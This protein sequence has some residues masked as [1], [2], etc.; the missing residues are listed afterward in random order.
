MTRTLA[1]LRR[2]LPHLERLAP[3]LAM[4]A[5]LGAV[6]GPGLELYFRDPF[7]ANRIPDDTRIQLYY[8]YHFSDPALFAGDPIGKY[9][10]DGIGDVVRLLY[11]IAAKLGDPMV[12]SRALPMLLLL[13]TVAGL[14]V[15][16]NNL[17]GKAGAMVAMTF[18]LAAAVVHDRVVGGLPRAFAYPCFAWCAAALTG[19]RVYAFIGVIVAG[20]GCYP[21][22]AVVG[23]IALAVWLLVMPREDRGAARDWSFRRR[24]L[25]LALTAVAIAAM[26]APFAL[27][28]RAYGETIRPSMVKEYPEA[29]PGGRVGGLDRPPF[30]PFFRA[31]APVVRE[32]ALARPESMLVPAVAAPIRKSGTWSFALPLLLAV[33]VG[34]GYLRLGLANAAARRLAALAVATAAGYVLANALTPNLVV[35]QRYVQ[36]PVPILV[37]LAIAG[38]LYGLV[39]RRLREDAT[40]RAVRIAAGSVLAVAALF[41]V[42]IGPG[43]PLGKRPSYTLRKPEKGLY[44]ALKALPKSALIA[45]WPV[46]ALDNIALATRRTPFLS[47]ETHYP[48]HTGMTQLMRQRMRALVAAYFATDEAPLLRL[49]N[50]FGVTHLLVEWSRLNASRLSY[51]RPFNSD[52]ERALSAARG[53]P[54]AIMS[55]EQTPVFRDGKYGL[56]DL[57]RLTPQRF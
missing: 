42:L 49:R 9:H 3:W 25:V 36:Y 13:A 47:R 52:I 37:P 16:G 19:G 5:V 23:G 51:F 12:L 11:I 14:A 2:A 46:G 28:M 4:V 29:G 50:E 22:C 32:S 43:G 33:G 54:L 15:A 31:L 35:P 21:I 26:V 38:G 30:P 39:P 40:P 8:F 56:F 24:L 1:S 17:A 44:T 57:T 55:S 53:H 20:T 48:Y 45:G 10:T 34:I 27:R 41:L 18:C 7:A 6:F